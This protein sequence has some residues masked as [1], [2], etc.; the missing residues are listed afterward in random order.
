MRLADP[1]TRKMPDALTAVTMIELLET[2]TIDKPFCLRY[3]IV[4][5]TMMGTFSRLLPVRRRSSRRI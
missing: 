1:E 5:D 3:V 4:C 2:W